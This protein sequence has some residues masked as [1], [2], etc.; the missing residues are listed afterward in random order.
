M[1]EQNQLRQE[2]ESIYFTANLTPDETWDWINENF[3]PR[4]D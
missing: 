3:V 4:E 2:F 1:T